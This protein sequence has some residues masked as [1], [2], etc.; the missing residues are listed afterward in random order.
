MPEPVGPPKPPPTP[1]ELLEHAKDI[2]AERTKLPRDKALEVVCPQLNSPEGVARMVEQL[3]ASAGRASEE[4]AR[5][6][7][8]EARIAKMHEITGDFARSRGIPVPERVPGTSNHFEKETWKISYNADALAAETMTQAEWELMRSVGVHELQHSQQFIDIVRYRMGMGESLEEIGRK[9]N[10]HRKG[11]EA[12]EAA[13]PLRPGQLGHKD[14]EAW[15]E[16]IFGNDRFHRERVLGDLE[17]YQ[18][19][20]RDWEKANKE[21]KELADSL[22][23]LR[24]DG[25]PRR[26]I[27]AK[28]Q[29]LAAAQARARTL[30]DSVRR[31][32]NERNAVFQEYKDLPE[33]KDA[34]ATHEE[35]QAAQRDAREAEEAR[36]AAREATERAMATGGQQPS[37][38]WDIQD[39]DAVWDPRADPLKTP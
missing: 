39:D 24:D 8:A 21:V 18:G 34:W 29:E 9:L 22:T 2:A 27:E 5:L 37:G 7:T 23:E 1:E 20:V 6:G 26:M 33:E 36:R 32:T 30:E 13:G 11:L 4:Y 12:A 17:K 15:Y 19:E 10:I 25:A 3:S 38:E 14:A 35:F 31:N 16:S 28:Q